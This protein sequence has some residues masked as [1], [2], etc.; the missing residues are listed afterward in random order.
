LDPATAVLDH[1][2]YVARTLTR[3]GVRGADLEDLAQEVLIVAIRRA[4]TFDRARRLEPWLFGIARN[5]ARDHRRLARHRVEQASGDD[6]AVPAVAAVSPA[7]HVEL[8]KRAAL[9]RAAV[10]ELD[11][12][13]QALI[14]LHDLEE[15]PMAEVAASLGMPVDTAYAR[16]RR[17]R[18]EIRT[19]LASKGGADG[20]A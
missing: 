19:R 20:L 3:L 17:A 16:L 11:E 9:L 7:E 6:I 2:D 1:I 5:V 4:N 18:G 14:V 10:A 8:N 13:L 12:P 15:I